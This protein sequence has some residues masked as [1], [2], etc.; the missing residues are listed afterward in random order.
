M[1]VA[2]AVALSWVGPRPGGHAG[3]SI[4][5]R[6]FGRG[7]H[8]T[9]LDEGPASGVSEAPSP[10]SRR[11]DPGGQPG[12]ARTSERGEGASAGRD[13]PSPQPQP[14]DTGRQRI[15]GGGNEPGEGE[16]SPGEETGPE[17]RDGDKPRAGESQAPEESAHENDDEGES[18]ASSEGSEQ[19]EQSGE[20]SSPESAAAPEQP[21]ERTG[22][23]SQ[24]SDDRDGEKEPS[25][26]SGPA[27]RAAPSEPTPPSAEPPGIAGLEEL[28]R[29]LLIA[30]GALA[31]LAVIAFVVR[32]VLKGGRPRLVLPRLP[33]LFRRGSGSEEFRN[34]FADANGLRDMPPREVVL[35]TYSAFMS[36]ARIC[37][38]PRPPH[39]TA[40]EFLSELPANLAG[41]RGEARELSRLYLQAEYATDHDFSD[42]L[43]RL[44]E[45]WNRLEAHLAAWRGAPQI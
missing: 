37:G 28:A 15:E 16:P 25:A 39:K 35:R 29:P 3:Q 36:L 9:L 26:E 45:I 21:S 7:D 18:A 30:L 6:D 33:R 5:A 40:S 23:E 14:G 22:S 2:G 11:T 44:G 41:L 8:R 43:P 1:V 19:S 27:A 10:P 32:A 13:A 4:V 12:Q 42:D 24:R 34:P 38:C 20:T 17:P 31:L